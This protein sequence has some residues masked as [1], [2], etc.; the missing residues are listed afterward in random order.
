MRRFPFRRSLRC[1]LLAS[2]CAAALPAQTRSPDRELGRQLFAEGD[3]AAAEA[4][5]SRDIAARAPD[6]TVLYNRALARFNQQKFHGAK[7][8]L[9]EFLKLSPGSA[10]GLGLRANVNL[11]RGD[12]AGALADADAALEAR[13]ADTETLLIRARARLALGRFDAA[14]A[15]FTDL[16]T[17]DPRLADALV[18]RGDV[19]LARGDL[20]GARA[21]LTRAISLAP[22][23]PDAHYKLGLVLFRLFD[24][25]AAASAADTADR[26]APKSARTQRLLGLVHYAIGDYGTAAQSFQASIA[27]DEPAGHY[28]RFMLLLC[29]RRLGRPISPVP[30]I[31]PASP[32]QAWPRLLRSFLL[33]DS[34]EDDLFLGAQNLVPTEA[35]AGRLC[36][37]GFYLGVV[38]AIENDEPAARFAFQQSIE[39]N[40]AEF[41]EHTLARV[42]LARLKPAPAPSPRPRRR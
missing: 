12:A 40:L 4:A 8:D 35:R 2:L 3:F 42:E 31:H 27:A 14:F 15:D 9:D 32:H 21:D 33:G 10:D 16:L 34:T 22:H 11:L 30:E 28:A 37:A 26:F 36:E 29:E 24:F 7:S 25:P 23:D 6:A 19:L 38:R 39:T 13:P 5:F 18:G 20:A 1:V 17:R 41:A